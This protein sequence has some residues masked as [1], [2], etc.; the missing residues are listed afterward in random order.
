MPGGYILGLR[1]QGKGM[2]ELLLNGGWTQ[3]MIRGYTVN[4]PLFFA[5]IINRPLTSSSEEPQWLTDFL[6]LLSCSCLSLYW[7][8]ISDSISYWSSQEIWMGNQKLESYLLPDVCF[9]IFLVGRRNLGHYFLLLTAE[10]LKI[11]TKTEIKR[12]WHSAFIT[13]TAHGFTARTIETSTLESVICC[14]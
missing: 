2:L 1:K 5:R 3:R 6:W 12:Q 10:C 7:D 11:K 13:F 9:I 14:C 8:L 4:L